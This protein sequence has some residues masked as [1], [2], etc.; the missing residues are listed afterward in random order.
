MEKLPLAATTFGFLYRCG[1]NEAFR[2][3]ASAGYQMV[4]L[5]AGPPHIDLS[6]MGAGARRGIK[7]ELEMYR[8]KCVST[9]PLELNPISANPDLSEAAFRQY[10]AAIELSSDLEAANVVMISGRMSPL[11]PMPV[12]QA[13]DLLRNQLDHLVPISRKLG[14]TLSIEAVP[15]GFLQTA[16]EISEFIEDYG[17]TNVGITVDCA[18]IHFAGGDSIKELESQ[19]KRLSVVHISDS[20]RHRWAHTQVGRA[21]IDFAAIGATLQRIDFRGP[22]VYELADAEDPAPRLRS[23]WD[24]LSRWGWTADACEI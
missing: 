7:R 15:Y 6:K 17:V 2:Q 12:P 22:T 24:S 16:T 10:R 1:R 5:A 21:E 11:V 19:S 8:L 20:W 9:N 14:V 4:E 13:K 3:A 23:D 18:N